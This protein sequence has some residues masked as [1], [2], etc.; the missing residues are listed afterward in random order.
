MLLSFVIRTLY[1][2]LQCVANYRQKIL[3]YLILVLKCVLTALFC[4]EEKSCL[5]ALKRKYEAL[6]ALE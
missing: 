2:N 1:H 6:R 5:K 3:P 4:L